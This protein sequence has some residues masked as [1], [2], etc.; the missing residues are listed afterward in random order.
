[1]IDR[2]NPISELKDRCFDLDQ[3][4]AGCKGVYNG[5]DAISSGVVVGYLKCQ[6]GP[7][8]VVRARR[9]I[10]WAFGVFG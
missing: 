5:F 1:M 8:P 3:V 4:L 10:S 9:G 2:V 7:G 6:V